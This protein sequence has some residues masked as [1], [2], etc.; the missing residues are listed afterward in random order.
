MNHASDMNIITAVGKR[1]AHSQQ[2]TNVQIDIG[3]AAMVMS[4][5]QLQFPQREKRV[6]NKRFL[7]KFDYKIYIICDRDHLNARK[8]IKLVV[9]VGLMLL[10]LF[11]PVFS[12][13]QK[14]SLRTAINKL[15][16]AVLSFIYQLMPNT[17]Q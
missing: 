12:L 7:K 2:L 4:A 1:E 11:V 10:K 14:E 17:L 15:T 13:V 16:N 8:T 3:S 9:G 6:S 5:K